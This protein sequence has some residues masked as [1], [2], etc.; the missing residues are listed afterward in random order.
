MRFHLSILLLLSFTIAMA[1]PNNNLFVTDWK[2]V[3]TFTDRAQPESAQKII[4]TILEKATFDNNIEQ[5]I[6]CLCYLQNLHINKDEDETKNTLKP[7]LDLYAKSNFPYKNIIASIIGEKYKKMYQNNRYQ[8]MNRTIID[9]EP[10]NEENTKTWTPSQFEN[11][12]EKYYNASL[13]KPADLATLAID[14]YNYL[15]IKGTANKNLRPTLFDFLTHRALEH[16]TSNNSEITKAAAQFT[17]KDSIAFGTMEEFLDWDLSNEKNSSHILQSL[18]LYQ[19]LIQHSTKNNNIPALL[20]NN[21]RRLQFVKDNCNMSNKINLYENAL[22]VIIKT[23][24]L[25]PEPQ[26]LLAQ[27]KI[28]QNIS[29]SKKTENNL[30]IAK[31]L[32]DEI[33]TYSREIFYVNSAKNLLQGITAK[34]LMMQTEKEWIPNEPALAKINYKNIKS[35]YLKVFAISL[36][37]FQEWQNDETLINK[38]LKTKPVVSYQR[39]LLVKNNYQIIETEIILNRLPVGFYVIV[40]AEKNA[41]NTKVDPICLSNICVTNLS[42]IGYSKAKNVDAY[43]VD[44]N[45]GMPLKDVSVVTSIPEYNATNRVHENVNKQN[46]T[47]SANGKFEILENKANLN[48]H[49][50]KGNDNLWLPNAINSYDYESENPINNMRTFIFTDRA[51]YRP[52]QS[53]YFKALCLNTNTKD[54]NHTVI[55]DKKGELIIRDANYQEIK[56]IEYTT[57]AFGTY[58]GSFVLPSNLLNGRFSIADKEFGSSYFSVEEYK[59]PKFEVVLDTVQESFKLNTKIK[60]DGKAKSY[61]GAIISNG[62]VVYRVKRTAYFPYR[63][64]FYNWGSPNVREVEITN[65]NT[66]TDENGKF[67]ITFTALPDESVNADTK[68]VYTF[69]IIADITDKNGETRTG[70]TAVS[71]SNTALLLSIDA[72]AQIDLNTNCNI[73]ISAKNLAGIPVESK[74]MVS[75]KKLE[76]NNTFYKMRYWEKPTTQ[77]LTETEFKKVF[78]SYEYKNESDKNTWKELE[79]KSTLVKSVIENTLLQNDL[80]F[81]NPGWYVVEATHIDKFGDTILEKKF[82]HA[83]NENNLE[84]INFNNFVKVSKPNINGEAM[85]SSCFTDLFLLHLQDQNNFKTNEIFYKNT[86]FKYSFEITENDKGGFYHQVMFVKNNRVYEKEIF[87]DVPFLNKK[88]DIN[89][90][91]FR[92][93]IEPGSKQEYTITISGPDK[94]K[95]QA[96]LLANMYDAS[97]DALQTHDWDNLNNLYSTRR[98]SFSTYSDIGFGDDFWSAAYCFEPK[99]YDIQ[100]ES[101][102]TF[103]WMNENYGSDKVYYSQS[104]AGSPQLMKS[105][106]MMDASSAGSLSLEAGIANPNNIQ[107]KL[108]ANIDLDRNGTNKETQEAAKPKTISPRTNLQETAF[109]YPQ[110]AIDKNGNIVLKFTAPDALTKWRLMFLAHTTD[111]KTAYAEKELVTQKELMVTPNIPR[112]FRNGDKIEIANK[113]DNLSANALEAT[114]NIEL[115]DANTNAVIN[116]WVID[117]VSKNINLPANGSANA[118][119]LVQIPEN[120]TNPIIVKLTASAGNFSDG[121]Q[122]IIPVIPNSKLITETV[123]FFVT[124]SNNKSYTLP[125]LL[126]MPASTNP[127]ALTVEFNANPAWYAV[128][129]LPYLTNYPYDCAEQ[130]FHKLYAN[131]IAAHIANSNPA[132]ATTY[133][134]WLEK[135]SNALKSNLQKNNELKSI[136]L[137]ETPWVLEAQSEEAQKRAIANLFNTATIESTLTDLVDQLINLQSV[138]GG[139]VW[140]KGGQD[141][142]YITNVILTGISRLQ[143][144]GISFGAVYEKLN[145]IVSKALPYVDARIVEQYKVAISNKKNTNLQTSYNDPLQYLYMRTLLT[146]KKPNANT[147]KAMDYYF[148]ETSKGWQTQT[149]YMKAMLA[150]SL[151]RANKNPALTKTIIQS[152]KETAV[153]NSELGMYWKQNAG[154]Y[155]HEAPI[156]A[157]SL[158]IELMQEIAKDDASVAQMKLYLLKQKQTNKWSNTIATANACYAL[159]LQGSDLISNTANAKITMGDMVVN[160]ARTT[161]EAGTGYTKVSFMANAI[162]PTMGNINVAVVGDKPQQPTWGS[163][164]YQY[165]QQLDKIVTSDTAFKVPM[166]ITKKLFKINLD[167]SGEILTPITEKTPL[168]IGD[169][170]RVRLILEA[171]RDLEF[172]HLHDMRSS[173]MEP[174]NVLSQYKYQEGMGYY[175]STKDASTNFFIGYMPKGTKVFEYTLTAF[176]RGI[177]SNGIATIQCM[178]APEFAAHSDGEWVEVQ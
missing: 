141:N 54:N 99:Y 129:S 134:T 79:T 20:H 81:N 151:A 95:V 173:N 82:I 175:E 94:E 162:K 57:N 55:K 163:V 96:E 122:V 25:A 144:L 60:I 10:I 15:L 119:W 102:P 46:Y 74:V 44:R 48:F 11:I 171:D 159:L 113:V 112:F 170:V 101:Y 87:V 98:R 93:K 67:E 153:K 39:E 121:E 140:F 156:E 76:D 115:L 164:Y 125:N 158:L 51:I 27:S 62:E 43:I 147:Q 97:L 68:P 149:A 105:S 143:H 107:N 167:A 31:K 136:L 111:A 35:L 120:Y 37:E 85:L 126:N 17:I 32:C 137:Q 38:L 161:K 75:I 64:C 9:S 114:T 41:P 52:G 14:K 7:F 26:L 84:P 19:A 124:T 47:T 127:H 70:T 178:Y 118:N 166:K 165:F 135:D 108:T 2:K 150:L 66:T 61:S 21:I 59:R 22:Q 73:K 42:M 53:V 90:A 72:P 139:F 91:S 1:Q 18:K 4:Y 45:S 86:P 65:G 177:C 80:Q 154:H 110:L 123:P 152:L 103:N 58:A 116:G 24:P 174:T 132:I 77:I 28:E 145:T 176:N 34:A 109:F 30:I 131:L 146:D 117:E 106:I 63:W 138:N 155:W 88:L 172:V 133:K 3:E 40:A 13:E 50:Y 23:N 16:F 157:Q 160:T 5:Q 33:I 71:I 100:N 169:K 89:I 29:D 69:E 6:K 36:K 128:Q 130:T 142:A 56:K 8:I 148:I 49:V 12:I 92:N 78:P 104:I 83:G 168:Q